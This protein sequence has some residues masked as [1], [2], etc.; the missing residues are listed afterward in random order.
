M[1]IFPSMK[2]GDL[3]AVLKGLGYSVERQKGSHQTLTCE[4]RPRLLFSFHGSQSIPPGLVRKVLRD[5]GLTVDEAAATL[6][7]RR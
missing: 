3:L 6:G 7:L 5:A 2:A 1:P 4:G